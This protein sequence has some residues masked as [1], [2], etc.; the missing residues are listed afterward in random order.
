MCRELAAKVHED[1]S[2]YLELVNVPACTRWS[3]VGLISA[4]RDDPR[5]WFHNDVCKQSA[6]L[7][8]IASEAWLK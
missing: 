8:L 2:H 7:P 5:G 3:T 1:P 4:V 6:E